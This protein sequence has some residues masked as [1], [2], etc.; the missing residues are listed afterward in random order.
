MKGSG[1]WWIFMRTPDCLE[2]WGWCSDHLSSCGDHLSSVWS[3]GTEGTDMG[4]ANNVVKSQGSGWSL[5]AEEQRG[6]K[7]WHLCGL[8]LTLSSSLWILSHPW[9]SQEAGRVGESGAAIALRLQDGG[10][11]HT[12]RCQVCSEPSGEALLLWINCPWPFPP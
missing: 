6:E 3:L 1:R 12:G 7:L 8:G 11:L 4:Q 5:W 9:S 10:R 2:I